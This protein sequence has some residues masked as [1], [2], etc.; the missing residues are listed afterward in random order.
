MRRCLI[1]TLLAASAA[2]AAP[3]SQDL[4][5]SVAEAWLAVRTYA[6]QPR[7][8]VSAVAWPNA[9][10]AA[11]WLVP[12]Q[13]EGF[14]LVSADDALQPV[15]GWSEQGEAT[16][17]ELPPAL[18]EFLVIVGREVR[19]ARLNGW[20]A[21]VGWHT[22]LRG[23]APASRELGVLPLLTCTWDQGAGWNAFCPADGGGPGG[24]VWAGCVAT[25]MGQIMH[26][27][28]QPWQGFGSHGYM[29][30]YGWLYADFSAAT[31]DWSQIQANSPTVEAA[32]LLYHCGIAVDMMYGPDGSGAYVGWGNPTALTAMRDNFG[33]SNAQFIAKSN[34]TWT[35]WR[36]RLR[37]ELDAGRPILHSGY[38][39]GG[40]AFNLDG[41]REDGYFHLNWGWSG[42][43]NGWFL[44]DA[45]TPGGNNFSEG[46]GAVVNLLPMQ[47]QAAPVMAH[48]VNNSEDVACTPTLFQW[49]AAEGALSYELVIDDDAGF[50]QPVLTLSG[51]TGTQVA[52]EDLLHYSQ[53]YWRIRSHGVQGTGPWSPTAGFFT[54]YW[55]QTPPPAPATPLNGAVNVN[56]DP[57]VL[58]WNFVTG[59]QSYRVQVSADP[60]FADTVVD[61]TGVLAHYVLLRN[62]LQPATTYWW[63][64]MCD[65]LAGWS[66]WSVIRNLT[67]MQT[68]HVP[69]GQVPADWGLEAAWPNPF[70]PAT[71]LSFQL[72]AAATVNLRVFNLLGVELAHLIQDQPLAAGRHH[73][74]WRAEGL[75]SGTYLVVLEA[76]GR[77]FVQKVTL[78]R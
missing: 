73:R 5:T 11:A 67:T 41:W 45:L 47:Y 52:V 69:A 18:E 59:A 55:D 68:T 29:S 64:V 33:Y 20:A 27:W 12:L 36:N 60:G 78:L 34:F 15:L 75:P 32:E 39:S 21:H 49:A 46:Q 38:G 24:R 66:E 35:G 7:S 13:P 3:V 31:Y 25:S 40:H 63:R 65:G 62:V 30:D 22:V 10:D 19:Q 16:A 42:A 56:L 51:L 28:Q 37:Q 72:G 74:T 6:G 77:R 2:L 57:T 9:D 71:Q 50:Q 23:D 76:S 70:N 8:A 53:Y 14:V 44:I 54:A 4:A 43:Y 61:T 58:V 26:Y 48:P 17:W 1:V